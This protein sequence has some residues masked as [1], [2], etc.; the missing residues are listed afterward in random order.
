[1]YFCICNQKYEVKGDLVYQSKTISKQQ[2]TISK[3]ILKIVLLCVWTLIFSYLPLCLQHGLLVPCWK[4]LQTTEL[5]N[6]QEINISYQYLLV[7]WQLGIH[8]RSFIGIPRCLK[9]ESH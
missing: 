9:S 8:Q 6:Q 1:M 3:T 4:T 7:C 5:A 2:N